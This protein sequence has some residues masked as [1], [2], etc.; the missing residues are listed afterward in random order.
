MQCVDPQKHEKHNT[1]RQSNCATTGFTD[2]KQG[3]LKWKT[4]LK[5]S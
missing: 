4:K 5:K 3:E 2:T 1:L